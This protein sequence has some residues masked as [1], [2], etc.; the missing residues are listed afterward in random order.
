MSTSPV[1]QWA[2]EMSPYHRGPTGAG[3]LRLAVLVVLV[4]LVWQAVATTS[5]GGQASTVDRGSL[6]DEHPRWSVCQMGEPD[7]SHDPVGR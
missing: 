2:R 7:G 5:G 3:M 1:P 6:C 4:V